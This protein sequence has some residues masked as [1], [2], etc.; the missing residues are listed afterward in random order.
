[1]TDEQLEIQI[2]QARQAFAESRTRE[3]MHER[4]IALASL[5]DRRSPQQVRRME[6]E[7]GLC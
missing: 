1:M 4:W 7:R 5:I 6:E 3:E 2:E